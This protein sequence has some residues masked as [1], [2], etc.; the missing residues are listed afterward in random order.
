MIKKRT[1]PFYGISLLLLPLTIIFYYLS[2]LELSTANTLFLTFFLILMSFFVYLVGIKR[3]PVPLPL[4]SLIVISFI[5]KSYYAYN[6]YS[7]VLSPFPD[8]FGYLDN[9]RKLTSF[10]SSYLL[11]FGFMEMTVG[12][13]QFFYYYVLYFMDFLF[14]NTF[15]FYLLNI[16]L[17]SIALTLLYLIVHKDFGE[18][19]AITTSIV[20]TLSM[21]LSI[22]TSNI[23][24]DSLVLFLTMLIY[25]LYKVSD[26][27]HLILIAV[28]I[29]CLTSTRIYAG[30]SV[31]AAIG[32]DMLLNKYSFKKKISKIVAVSI[33]LLFIFVAFN[34]SF[35]S[36]YMSLGE[37]FISGYSII[38]IVTII[39][40]TIFSFI[41]EPYPWGVFA[42]NHTIYSYMQID[43]ALALMFSFSLIMFLYKFLKSKELRA[44]MYFYIFP[45]IIHSV[46]LGIAYGGGLRQKIG[47][48]SFIILIYIVGLMYK[49]EKQP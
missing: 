6:T 41:F 14:D 36:R 43:S 16:L 47:A 2:L 20:A 10:D 5:L 40:S 31:L 25:Y 46:A 11:D 1:L 26:K 12:T 9:L 4:I 29:G 17:G 38:D 28:L 22:F 13:S 27:R 35:L 21:T 23:L 37:R 30:L 15:S 19:I 42:G 32:I 44:K 45:I 33:L 8:S 24:K 49:R 18:K 34:F 39:P 3:Q 48:F 7:T